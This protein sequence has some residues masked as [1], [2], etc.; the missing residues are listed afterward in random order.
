MKHSTLSSKL[1]RS[2]A[3]VSLSFA[4]AAASVSPLAL[5]QRGRTP[6]PPNVAAGRAAFEE[7]VRYLGESRFA[8][9]AQSF[10]RSYQAN[11]NP[12]VLY[13]LAFAY[14]GLGRIRD[15]ISAIDR[16]I[17]QPASSPA[18]RVAA[19]REERDRLAASL[20]RLTITLAPTTAQLVI[21]ARPASAAEPLALDP[22]THIVE[23]RN[24]GYRPFREELQ[25][26]AGASRT[27]AVRLAE[28]D[29]QGRLRVEPSVPT[30]RVTID[31]TYAGTGA[32]ETG[33]RAGIHRV[34][35]TAEGYLPLRREVRV[36]GTGLVRVDAALVRPRTNTWVWLGPV[37][38]ASAIAVGFGT[39]GIVELSR[40]EIVPN[41]DSCWNCGTFR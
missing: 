31:G 24:D 13:N 16:F 38:A 27:L 10:E 37:L 30:A 5:A 11:P 22:G 21:D 7:G 3:L 26:S 23:A 25:L 20:A 6:E 1:R 18:D 35:I 4:L 17:A 9:A 15:A 34:D 39:W 14:R 32:L 8:D 28:I 29:D 33:V 36:G 12:I 2:R 19:A 41:V 40:G